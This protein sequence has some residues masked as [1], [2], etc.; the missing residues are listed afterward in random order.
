MLQ[1]LR[2]LGMPETEVLKAEAEAKARWR[3]DDDAFAIHPD[4]VLAVKV[5]FSMATQWRQASLT[6]STRSMLVR[7]G[8]DYG[9]LDD[10]ARRA[11]LPPLEPH[12]FSR[13]Q[14]LEA[15]AL[16]AWREE[17]ERQS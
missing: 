15:E 16:A 11:G 8:L 4:N 6:T 3:L 12:D 1:D 5:F 14:L 7:T 9:A 2:V 13:L 10:T 17:R